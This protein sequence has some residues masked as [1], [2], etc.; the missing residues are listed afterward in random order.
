MKR[1]GNQII[2][3][4]IDRNGKSDWKVGIKVKSGCY[5][6]KDEMLMKIIKKLIMEKKQ[7]LNLNVFINLLIHDFR[8]HGKCSDN[9]NFTIENG[10]ALVLRLYKEEYF[11]LFNKIIW[12]EKTVRESTVVKLFNAYFDTRG[13]DFTPRLQMRQPMTFFSLA[14]NTIRNKKCFNITI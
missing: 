3:P 4:I 9:I 13:P 8:C 12:W 1:T 10:L 2:I 7:I 11:S 5:E 6:I 14:A